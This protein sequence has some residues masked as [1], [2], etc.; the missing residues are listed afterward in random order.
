MRKNRI[1][2]ALFCPL[3]LG[4]QAPAPSD[5]VT[6][7][8]EKERA[9]I[10]GFVQSVTVPN[11]LTGKLARW[12]T[13]ICPIAMGVRKKAAQF[14]TKRL[15]DVAQ[16][17]G[18]PVDQDASCKPNIQIVFTTTPQGLLDNIR[19][20]QEA[21]LGYA[22]TK[23][24]RDKLALFQD[25]I[26][27]LYLTQT[28]DLRGKAQIDSG[29]T[30]G[31]LEI[32]MYCDIC[33]PPYFTMRIPGASAGAV[34]GSRALGDGLRSTF[35]NVIVVADPTK[36]VELEMGPLSD[37]VTLLALSQVQGLEKCQGLSSI[38]NL[39]PPGCERPAA[40][41]VADM[42]YLRGLYRMNAEQQSAG[43]RDFVAWQ[44]GQALTGR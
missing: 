35:Y 17:A 43:Q 44:M 11:R 2:L 9:T 33:A 13:P 25:P 31:Q 26:K 18:A 14:I 36:L 1:S 7:T 19:K 28:V 27:A 16:Q 15:K 23:A 12:E 37:Y 20:Q 3:L 38:V 6:V 22:D 41:T 4:A 10:N 8:S 42:G 5:S 39:L 29:K 32:Q 40:M 24:Q 30:S 21:F 34:T